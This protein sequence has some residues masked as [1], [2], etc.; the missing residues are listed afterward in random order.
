M[1]NNIVFI[2]NSEPL[3]I[4][5]P[6]EQERVPGLAFLETDDA[7]E[8]HIDMLCLHM[9]V[10][11]IESGLFATVCAL[12]GAPH[13][14]HPAPDQEITRLVPLTHHHSASSIVLP[15]LASPGH[16]SWRAGNSVRQ[17]SF[18]LEIQG[19]PELASYWICSSKL[20]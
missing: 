7:F 6:M 14:D 17:D 11:S 18:L 1:T 13:L 8:R 2:N 12:P 16:Q 20:M 15:P 4:A 9:G 19:K 3:M 5:R 10:E